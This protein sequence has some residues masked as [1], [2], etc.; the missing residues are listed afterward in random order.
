MSDRDSDAGAEVLYVEGGELKAILL[1]R[2]LNAAEKKIHN[3]STAV[4]KNSNCKQ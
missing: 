1:G 3:C 4:N 2:E